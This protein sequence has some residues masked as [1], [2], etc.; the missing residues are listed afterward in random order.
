[1]EKGSEVGKRIRATTSKSTCSLKADMNVQ[2]CKAYPKGDAI[3]YEM[4]FNSI[5]E[6][7]MRANKQS[8]TET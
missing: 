2:K 5:Q 4:C 1:M 6:N 7:K 8:H 3:I